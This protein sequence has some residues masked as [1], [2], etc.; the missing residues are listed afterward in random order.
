MR[1][2]DGKPTGHLPSRSR[3]PPD[4]LEALDVYQTE[5]LG[6]LSYSLLR[7]Y[8][9]RTVF[10]LLVLYDNLVTAMTF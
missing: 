7:R 9:L 3:T 1:E 10:I 2:V 5:H 6:L 4:L 8:V